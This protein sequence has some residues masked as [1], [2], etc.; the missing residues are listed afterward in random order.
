MTYPVIPKDAFRNEVLFIFFSAPRRGGSRFTFQSFVKSK[1][2]SIV[3]VK[4]IRHP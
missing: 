1:R 3:N 4:H 2:I